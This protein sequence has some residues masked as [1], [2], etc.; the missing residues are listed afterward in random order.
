MSVYLSSGYFHTVYL[1][2]NGHVYSFGGNDYGQLGTGDYIDQKIPKQIID[3]PIISKVS[4][5]YK[6]TVCIDQNGKL[7]SFGSNDFGQLG[8]KNR[9]G[10]SKPQKIPKLSNVIDVT[11]GG[12]HTL[13]ILSEKKELWSCGYNKQGQLCLGHAKTLVTYFK[14][15]NFS[16]IISISA[17]YEFTLFQNT[18]GEIYACGYNGEGQLGIGNRTIQFQPTLI[19]NLPNPIKSFSCGASH[20]IFLD[21]EGFVY[22]TGNNVNGELGFDNCE[23]KCNL[24]RIDS[25]PTIKT[26]ACGCNHTLCIDFEG[27]LW[28]FGRNVHGQLGL[29][30]DSNYV[31]VPSLLSSLHASI[32]DIF[33]GHSSHNFIRSEDGT[34]LVFGKNTNG[35]LTMSDK[36][37]SPFQS[38]PC[39]IKKEYFQNNSNNGE[40]VIIN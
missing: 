34:I 28:S 22:S 33:C 37:C 6:F 35:Q 18:D 4:C 13:C 11:C 17:G 9:V 1:S 38:T 36:I 3:L 21:I 32:K 12:F 20:S 8:L 14:P 7:W 26:I 10:Q 25:I 16:N 15:A 5:G 23:F 27:K 19:P 30:D 2:D 31:M 40:T 24:T 29:G 39:S